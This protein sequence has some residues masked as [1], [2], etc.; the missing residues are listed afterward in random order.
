MKTYRELSAS[1]IQYLSF[2][3]TSD[4][5]DKDG[6]TFEVGERIEDDT[7]HLTNLS[8]GNKGK[9]F[10]NQVIER[11][12]RGVYDS[13]KRVLVK[14]INANDILFDIYRDKHYTVLSFEL[15]DYKEAMV[16]V[17]DHG[18]NKQIKWTKN[19]VLDQIHRDKFRLISNITNN[20]EKTTVTNTDIIR[21]GGSRAI[22]SSTTRLITIS[23]RLVGNAKAGTI[24]TT[25]TCSF[26]ISK[27]SIS[28]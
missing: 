25:R 23:S 14:H 13:F 19:Y 11:T 12:K 15:S 8:T 20:N 27:N 5:F 10:L 22:T 9:C 21:E 28:I 26:K 18:N 2:V 7:Y 1:G 6:Y 17:K 16:I 24:K 3:Q 4:R